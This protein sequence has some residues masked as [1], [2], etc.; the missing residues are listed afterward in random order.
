MNV[1]VCSH[2]GLE[3]FADAGVC[4]LDARGLEVSGF[5]IRL[6]VY[7]AVCKMLAATALREPRRKPNTTSI[8][9]VFRV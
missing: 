4:E 6:V 2:V 8:V 1:S 3:V 5:W 7:R 9:T